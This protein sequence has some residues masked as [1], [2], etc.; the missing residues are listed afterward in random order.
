MDYASR[1][2]AGVR[3]QA[4]KAHA[5]A[6]DWFEVQGQKIIQN[7]I[8]KAQQSAKREQKP[9]MA[10]VK[11]VAR[12]IEQAHAQGLVHGSICSSVTIIG[13]KAVIGAWPDQ[14]PSTKNAS[15]PIHPSDAKAH[16]ITQLTDRLALLCWA[17]SMNRTQAICLMSIC[18]WNNA[19]P[20]FFDAF[21]K[22]LPRLSRYKQVLSAYA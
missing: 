3:T 9:T 5:L 10:H 7:A 6:A 11:Q 16:Q 4:S 20:K 2:P 14:L 1:K 21:L 13:A 12:Q 19:D 17:T 18:G 22:E 8:L 15:G